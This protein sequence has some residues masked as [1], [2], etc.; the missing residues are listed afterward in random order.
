VKPFEGAPFQSAVAPGL[1]AISERG[2][3]Q[4]IKVEGKGPNRGSLYSVDID[5]SMLSEYPYSNRWDYGLWCGSDKPTVV[6][7]EA[8]KAEAGEV[9]IVIRKRQWL[10]GL[11][12]GTRLPQA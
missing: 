2:Y 7:I 1:E 4:R 10:E 9:D 5:S 3:H 6:F 12:V 11:L 8:H